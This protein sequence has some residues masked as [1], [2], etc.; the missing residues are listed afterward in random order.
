MLNHSI[1]NCIFL[2]K[3]KGLEPSMSRPLMQARHIEE[4]LKDKDTAEAVDCIINQTGGL[5][6]V[7]RESRN[8]GTSSLKLFS[9]VCSFMLFFIKSLSHVSKVKPAL[10]RCCLIFDRP[11]VSNTA[12]SCRSLHLPCSEERASAVGPLHQR[13]HHLPTH[14]T[15]H[16]HTIPECHSPLDSSSS[17]DSCS[18]CPRED[19]KECK[20]QT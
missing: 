16:R 6:A 5:K 2:V 1:P 3:L 11:S 13:Q 8:R 4:D 20:F 9:S 19:Q 10:L 15:R 17:I 7:Q 12:K 14:S 18:S